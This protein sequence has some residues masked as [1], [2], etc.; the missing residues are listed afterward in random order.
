MTELTMP[1][2]LRQEGRRINHGGFADLMRQEGRR[3]NHG[4]FADL[5]KDKFGVDCVL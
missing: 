5:S 4:G 3:I 1:N 2:P